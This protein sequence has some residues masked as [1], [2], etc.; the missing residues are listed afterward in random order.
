MGPQGKVAVVTG[1]A[2][3]LGLAAVR[4]LLEDGARVALVDLDAL[5]LD[6]LSRFL[7]GERIVVAAD[8][9][10]AA[11]VRAA[12]ERVASELGPVDILVN[13]AGASSE[14]ALAATDE[15]TWRRIMAARVSGTYLWSREVF[16][17][18]L[19]RGWG[20]IV[21]VAGR[22]SAT[23]PGG[24]ADSAA[25]GAIA[26]FTAELAREGAPRGVTVNAVAPAFVRSSTSGGF[27]TDAQERQI[28]ASIPAGRFGE[29]EE[30]AHAVR[31]FASPLSAFVTGQTLRV[32]GGYHLS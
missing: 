2:G 24:P 16:P 11:A 27:L 25:D 13:A 23:S 5:R 28:L 12:H 22:A 3:T 9:T 14:G 30:F 6:T 17:A 10:D 29:P 18:M 15:S 32:D 1:G 4:A 8:V 26:S 20:R 21:N 31:F 7:R 19:S